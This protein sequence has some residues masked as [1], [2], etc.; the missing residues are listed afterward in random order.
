ML[1]RSYTAVLEK[2][3][4]YTENFETEPYETAWAGEALWFVRILEL[5]DDT[6]F[7]ATAQISPDG[8][9]WCDKGDAPLVADKPGVYPLALRDFGGWLRLRC[10]VASH[11]K[12]MVYLVLKE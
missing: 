7:T 4:T 11:V 8:L 12:L 5:D 6:T 3:E 1:K 2:N 9:F 10:D